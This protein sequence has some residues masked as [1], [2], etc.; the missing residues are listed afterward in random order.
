MTL[1]KALAGLTGT[2]A[3]FLFSRSCFVRVHVAACMR[4]LCFCA[5]TVETGAGGNWGRAYLFV[6]K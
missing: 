4:P 5:A 3:A 1:Q 2:R 6:R